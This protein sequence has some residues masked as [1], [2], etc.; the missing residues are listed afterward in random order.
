MHFP[1]I[2]LLGHLTD[3]PMTK[4]QLNWRESDP[5]ISPHIPP[6]VHLHAPLDFKQPPRVPI[7]LLLLLFKRQEK[8]WVPGLSKFDL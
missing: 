7:L 4:L 1:P 8:G 5:P 3:H 2:L 6:T